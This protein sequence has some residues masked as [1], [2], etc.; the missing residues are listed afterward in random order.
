MNLIILCTELA[1][2]NSSEPCL[3][4]HLAFIVFVWRDAMLI[5][6]T[7]SLKDNTYIVNT[8]SAVL[9]VRSFCIKAVIKWKVELWSE[10]QHYMKYKLHL[11]VL[12]DHGLFLIVFQIFGQ[13]EDFFWHE[14]QTKI[15][16]ICTFLYQMAIALCFF[17]LFEWKKMKAMILHLSLYCVVSYETWCL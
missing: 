4:I 12:D 7:S 10:N 2:N 8:S 13:P 16:Y 6:F 14:F 3:I 9:A 11:K 15:M 5:K 17:F 1:M